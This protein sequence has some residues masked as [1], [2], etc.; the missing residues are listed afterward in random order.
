MFNFKHVTWFGA[1]NS[2]FVFNINNRTFSS[3]ELK[4]ALFASQKMT[5]NT[6]TLRFDIPAS[7][8][9]DFSATSSPIQ[10][11]VNYR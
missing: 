3:L 1:I 10:F 7:G 6:K 4:K 8:L 11:K 5:H 2:K 9:L